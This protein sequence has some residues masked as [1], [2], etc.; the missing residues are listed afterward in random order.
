MT[1]LSMVGRLLHCAYLG[2]VDWVLGHCFC[3]CLLDCD[4]CLAVLG[5]VAVL[6]F[7]EI[8]LKKMQAANLG[9]LSTDVCPLKVNLR[10][11]HFSSQDKRQ[12][13]SVSPPR[14][15]PPTLRATE[16]RLVLST[17]GHHRPTDLQNHSR[18]PPRIPV[19]LPSHPQRGP[20]DL[21]EQRAAGRLL[22]PAGL[23]HRGAHPAQHHAP[24]G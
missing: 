5:R 1:S 14:F 9:T 3:D 12:P 10:E 21:A 15:Q 6:G 23:S 7:V 2:W 4:S 22:G 8:K 17:G 24:P 18:R 19:V 16:S 20:G 13:H 11:Q